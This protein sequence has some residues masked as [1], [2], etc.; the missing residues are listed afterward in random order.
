LAKKDYQN[1]VEMITVKNGTPYL[2][3]LDISGNDV[4]FLNIIKM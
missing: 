1:I 3:E 2:K 4:Y